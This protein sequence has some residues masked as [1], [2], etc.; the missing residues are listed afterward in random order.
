MTDSF[1]CAELLS[2]E[3]N[4]FG[5]VLIRNGLATKEQVEAAAKDAVNGPA[6]SL[7]EAV[8]NRGVMSASMVEMVKSAI[9]KKLQERGLSTASLAPP[10][11]SGVLD[12]VKPDQLRETPHDAKDDEERLKRLVKRIV[13]SRFHMRLL[14]HVL[15]GQIGVLFADRLSKSLGVEAR[16]VVGVLQEWKVR[17]V[18]ETTSGFK[19]MFS[20]APKDLEDMR[21]LMRMW[22]NRR[23]HAK[24]LGWILREEFG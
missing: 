18:V 1:K 15:A 20:P 3:Q 4:L 5:R 11:A 22:T 13:P 6:E 9:E 2:P 10:G 21:S 7:E 24:V 19:F 23:T 16:R 12:P 17:G 14:D 8:V